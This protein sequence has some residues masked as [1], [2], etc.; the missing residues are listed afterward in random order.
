[1]TLREEVLRHSGVLN[2]ESFERR[3][4]NTFDDLFE[5]EINKLNKDRD[6]FVGSDDYKKWINVTIKPLFKTEEIRKIF[7][8]WEQ[9]LLFELES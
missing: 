5:R 8:K 4:K 1:M 2:E 9:D 7:E 6:D 3:W